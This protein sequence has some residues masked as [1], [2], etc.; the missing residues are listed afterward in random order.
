M[1]QTSVPQ[2]SHCTAQQEIRQHNTVIL[3]LTDG[4]VHTSHNVPNQTVQYAQASWKCIRN[5][6]ADM[7]WN[8]STRWLNLNNLMAQEDIAW[9]DTHIWHSE[10]PQRIYHTP[11]TKHK[12]AQSNLMAREDTAWYNTHIWHSGMPQRSYHTPH[13]Q[14]KLAQ[15]NLMAREDTAWYN[16][17][18]WHSEMPQ[19]IYHTPHTHVAQRKQ[20]SQ[21]RDKQKT[22]LLLYSPR[23]CSA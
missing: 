1:T 23:F 3:W 2:H 4:I 17:H 7:S 15:S 5:D 9:S 6:T 11:H 20:T 16:A 14:N 19:C 12:L 10:M 8:G 22:Y 18:I 21:N 13:T